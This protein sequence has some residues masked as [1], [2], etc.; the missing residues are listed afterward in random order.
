MYKKLFEL[1]LTL[2]GAPGDI[3]RQLA[4]IMGEVLKVKAVCLFEIQGEQLSFLTV[5]HAGEIYCNAGSCALA[6]SPCA[7]VKQTLAFTVYDQVQARFPEA[8]FLQDYNAFAYCG[9]P[10]LDNNGAV[11]GIICLLDDKPHDFTA[12]DEEVLRIFG[13]RLGMEIVR[14][15]YDQTL[16][17]NQDQLHQVIRL[18]GAGVFDYR[19]GC[20]PIF[21]SPELRALFGL[22]DYEPVTLHTFTDCVFLADQE[23][24]F[25]AIRLSQNPSGNGLV[26]IEY[27]TL[28]RD[29]EVRWL[30][31]RSQTFFRLEAET[32]RAFRT[33]GAVQDISEK[34]QAEHEQRLFATAFQT[35]EGIMIAD[36]NFRI[37]RVNQAFSDI[38]GYS[39]Q[40]ALGNK[41]AML[42]SGRHTPLFFQT[43]D[44]ALENY[45]YWQGE[46]WDRHKDG[47]IYPKWMTI[48]AVKDEF[49]HYVAIFSDISEHKQT[50]TKL[51]AIFDAAREGI[52]SYDMS[53]KI[54]SANAAVEAIF[55]YKP[56]E[57]IGGSI[58][59]LKLSPE[60][61]AGAVDNPR[62]VQE[63]VGLHKNG[64][65]VPLDISVAEYDIDNKRY[66]T[67]IIRDTT[68]RKEREAQ[69]RL[70]L[71]EL[72]HV[73]RL[74]LMGEMASGIA[75]EINQPLTAITNYTQASLNIMKGENPDLLKLARILDK[76]Q[77]QAFRAGQII[78]RMRAFLQS[79]AKQR[80]TDDIN[81]LIHDAVGLCMHEIHQ[82]CIQLAFNLDYNLPKVYVDRIQ[83]EQ[84]LINLIR[85]SI[86]V[87]QSLPE[88]QARQLSIHSRLT[89]CH[90]I[91]LR[92]KDNGPGMD[93]EQQQ[94]IMMPFYTTKADG[95]GMG[96]SICR[97][98]VESHDGS[99]TFNSQVGKGTSFYLILP[100]KTNLRF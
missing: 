73:T 90:E 97:S 18:S 12:K 4:K 95:L 32:C 69:G 51:N 49:T 57:L 75:H 16:E 56:D 33:V 61:T 53:D 79:G 85:N 82:H 64:D 76:T 81:E 66:F 25:N 63:S 31:V 70:H 17:I 30:A 93:R 42:K 40:E 38:T 44:A 98:L 48:T 22:D 9:F 14:K 21:C 10:A 26:D 78:H 88:K 20:E 36:A 37:V 1:C 91:Q 54:V 83:I 87:L 99:L 65:V 7:T 46:I 23:R 52:V 39:A 45:G 27:R 13:Q 74:G 8:A 60:T 77:Q 71:A 59:K 29:G 72:A 19:H 47:H 34:K 3:F 11:V 80:T 43:L 35:K 24:V 68:Q 84:V 55:G 5:Y 89:D 6:T 58:R 86:E 67:K 15:Q 41:P 96:L 2:S 50:E 62:H 100:I 92:V 94:K 28:R